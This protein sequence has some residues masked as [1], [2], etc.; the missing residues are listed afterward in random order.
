[1]NVLGI[2]TATVVC[3]AAVVAG[4]RVLSDERIIQKNAHAER[5]MSLVEGSLTKAGMRGMSLD[6]IAVSIG[7]GSF[8]GLRIGLSV[9]KGLAYATR[10][11]L[12]AV[13]T[14]AALTEH[15][16]S[17]AGSFTHILAAL[18]ARRDEVYCQLFRIERGTPVPLWP[19]RAA[20][21]GELVDELAGMDVFVTGDGTTKLAEAARVKGR[22]VTCASDEA[23]HCSASAVALVG[24][25]MLLQ[26][27]S[28]DPADVQPL[29]VK[30]FH[31]LSGYR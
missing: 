16:V 14:L 25:R 7:P 8:T 17:A 27:L 28:A 22:H 10:K 12:I 6:G 24:V 4:G 31:T 5:L 21:V 26:G 9:A 3:G 29:Y 15:S 20:R 23:L 30:E 18:D 19:E 1:M 13:P 11:P 2:E